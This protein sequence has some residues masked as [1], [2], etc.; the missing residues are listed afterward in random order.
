MLPKRRENEKLFSTWEET[1]K[2][3]RRYSRIV[4]GKLGWSAKY[5]KLVDKNEKTVKFWQEIYNDK[6]KLVE[7]Q[8]KFPVDKGHK[9]IKK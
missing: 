2:G 4:Q 8:E 3:E 7:I 6:G 1:K 9:K 5:I